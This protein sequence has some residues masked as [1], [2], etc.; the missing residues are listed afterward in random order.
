[1]TPR[2]VEYDVVK[3]KTSQ[4]IRERVAAALGSGTVCIL[5]LVVRSRQEIPPPQD[6][7]ISF[8]VQRPT[9]VEVST[10]STI[11]GTQVFPN[12][13]ENGPTVE[14]LRTT[15]SVHLNDDPS[16]APTASVTV[17]E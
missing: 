8:I 5:Q 3:P 2:I 7:P 11:S 16:G 13:G 14:M 17:E 9:G 4:E 1:M 6:L 10:A 15:V 12:I